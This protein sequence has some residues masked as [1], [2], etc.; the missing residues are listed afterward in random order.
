MTRAKDDYAFWLL[1]DQYPDPQ[2]IDNAPSGTGSEYPTITPTNGNGA[3]PC[4]KR[5]PKGRNHQINR[6]A[7]LSQKPDNNQPTGFWIALLLSDMAK[8]E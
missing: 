1:V 5:Q 6:P 3:F 4:Y 8:K 7:G 2:I